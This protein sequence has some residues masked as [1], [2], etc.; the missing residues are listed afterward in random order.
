MTALPQII[1]RAA[2]RVGQRMGPDR[3]DSVAAVAA[4]REDL[5]VVASQFQQGW[6]E[7][8]L[9]G[10]PQVMPGPQRAE[11]PFVAWTA[12]LGWVLVEQCSADGRW[13]Y[14]DGTGDE[15]ETV[16]AL[17][18]AVCLA[19]PRREALQEAAVPGAL[20]LVWQSALAHRRV[21]I[22][23]LLATALVSLLALGG[24][25]YSMQ[26]YDR[27]IPNSGTQTL[28]VLTVGATVAALLEFLLKQLRSG[29]M[30]R[31]CAAIDHSLS[32]WFFG[33]L[34]GIRMERR[35]A[36]VGTLAAQAKGF[37]T[38]RAALTSTSLFVLADIPFAVLFVVVIALVGG[39][40]VL[41]PL[42]ALPLAL[43]CGLAFRQATARH[44][45]ENLAASHRKQGLLV[46]AIDGAESL[47]ATGGEWRLQS[48][49]NQLLHETN[50]PDLATRSHSTLSQNLTVLMQ[51]VSYIALIATGAWLVST[52]AL[53][54]GGLLACSII[55]NRAMSPIIQLPGVML[56]WAHARAAIEGLDRIIALPN[57]SD[58]ARHALI[59]GEVGGQLRMQGVRHAYSPGRTALDVEALQAQQGE[60]V[61][62]LGPIGS[63]KSTLLKLL[64]GLYRPDEGKVHLGGLDMALLGPAVIRE[65]VGYLPQ[66]V[67]LFSGTL[68]D[69]LL[70]GL[71]DPGDAALL[72]AAT[73]TGLIDLISGQ[74]RGL[75]LEIHEGSRGVSGG[76]RQLIGF[77]RLLLARP[78]IWL[79]DEPTGSMDSVTEARI[80][81]LLAEMRREGVTL[82]LSTHK[83]ALLP[84]VDRLIVLQAGKVVLD[85]PRQAVLERL[86]GR[87]AAAGPQVVAP[88]QAHGA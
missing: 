82:V 16:G 20:Q 31:V 79:L 72:A 53:T 84:L 63:G 18:E 8:G 64:S 15:L 61:G 11:L 29:S 58:D 70:L 52:N 39:W 55:S 38:V 21:F 26:V 14:S 71:P 49:W 76:Q 5:L 65:G 44:M 10:E 40:L 23:A 47:K 22:D 41:I 87:P 2:R 48:R 54:M 83:T 57:E 45:R 13:R 80:V 73:R 19:L 77:T 67:R 50:E 78:R 30:D 62:V 75:A 24:S 32:E 85:G 59:P 17:A 3:R 28:W 66:D 25:L 69:N 81:G 33:R 68:R 46:E 9:Q 56:Q 88:A 27:V 35:P 37:E 86:S 34:M 60:A 12:Q 74:P 4:H 7:A 43:G 1:D 42:V 51:Q 6:R 36:S